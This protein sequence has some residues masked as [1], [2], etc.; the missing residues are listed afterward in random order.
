MTGGIVSVG[1]EGREIGEFVADL[2]N[3]GVSTLVDVRLNPISRKAGFSKTRLAD[4][5]AE[6]GIDYR[7]YRALGNPKENRAAFAKSPEVGSAV[8][9]DLL[10]TPAARMAISDLAGCTMREVVAVLCFERDHGACHRQ[11]VVEAVVAKSG[12]PVIMA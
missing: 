4:A 1:Y 9:R 3:R 2:V 10:D 11:V 6:H 7:H 5:L 8:I 12:A